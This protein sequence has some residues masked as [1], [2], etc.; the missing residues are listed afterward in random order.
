MT[1]PRLA[2]LAGQVARRPVLASGL[3]AGRLRV[4]SRVLGQ[5]LPV[6]WRLLALLPARAQ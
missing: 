3:V 6:P 5:L 1:R 2:P 4:P